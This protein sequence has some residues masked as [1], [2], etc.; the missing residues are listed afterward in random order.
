[1]CAAVCSTLK[2]LQYHI[3]HCTRKH[4]DCFSTDYLTLWGIC[5]NAIFTQKI[6]PNQLYKLDIYTAQINYKLL[7]F[8]KIIMYIY[9]YIYIYIYDVCAAITL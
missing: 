2:P 1:M 3:Q 7:I 6:Q 5:K 8:A 4:E 9:I